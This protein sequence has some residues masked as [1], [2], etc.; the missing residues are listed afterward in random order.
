[1]YERP[2]LEVL[3]TAIPWFSSI[4]STDLSLFLSGLVCLLQFVPPLTVVNIMPSSPTAH[5]FV[6][7]V[8]STE[9]R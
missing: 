4:K 2:K 6:L 7:S 5:P 1:M 9:F 8:K 3:P